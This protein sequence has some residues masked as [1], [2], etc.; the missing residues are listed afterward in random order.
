MDWPV[1]LPRLAQVLT[2]DGVLVIIEDAQERPPW[3]ADLVRIILQHTTNPTLDLTYDWIAELKRQG[4]FRPMGR[5]RT[6][7]I[8]FR[9][10]VEA[11]VESFHGRASFARELWERATQPR[12]TPPSERWS[13]PTSWARSN[14]TCSP[15]SP[16]VARYPRELREDRQTAEVADGFGNGAR[17][18]PRTFLVERG[19][20]ADHAMVAAI[21]TR[22]DQ[23]DSRTSSTCAASPPGPAVAGIDALLLPC[24]DYR[25]TSYVTRYMDVR[26]LSQCWW[27]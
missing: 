2:S 14:C 18:A 27:T 4:W 1:V 8:L 3:Q 11:Y 7:A 15:T 5:E 9:Q 19:P 23:D 6:P 17:S 25:L 13:Q 20:V 16:G 22:S 10:S 26:R 24:I 12:S 21:S